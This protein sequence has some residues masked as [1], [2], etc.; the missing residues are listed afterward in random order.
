[1]VPGLEVEFTLPASAHPHF[2]GAVLHGEISMIF[3]DD[4]IRVY[5]QGDDPCTYL[6][7]NGQREDHG[8]FDLKTRTWN[9]SADP[10]PD[11]FGLSPGPLPAGVTIEQ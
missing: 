6:E 3:S 11:P 9:W 7:H 1:M 4:S 8:Y 2:A 10:N 5:K